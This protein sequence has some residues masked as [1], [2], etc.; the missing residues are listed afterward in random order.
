MRHAGKLEE[1]DGVLQA[2]KEDGLEMSVAL[3]YAFMY[4]ARN[5]LD[6]E[7]AERVLEIY[8]GNGKAME[9]RM[10]NLYLLVYVKS[11]RY[12][13][14]L[15][16]ILNTYA[17]VHDPPDAETFSLVFTAAYRTRQSMAVIDGIVEELLK[18]GLRFSS[19]TGSGALIGYKN[20]SLDPLPDRCLR[21]ERVFNAIQ[22]KT[23]ACYHT[24]ISF[25]IENFD[26]AGALR[27]QR[28]ME[29]AGFSS[30]GT[31]Y[32]MMHLACLYTGMAAYASKYEKLWKEHIEKYPEEKVDR[33]K[34][35]RRY[36]RGR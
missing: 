33:E 19:T 34:R 17:S 29:N 21:A 9:C 22:D 35:R 28:D 12:P 32:K 5:A 7:I 13:Q 2:F 14:D 1:L 16:S 20:C 10:L 31:T 23:Q 3:Y 6:V 30:C 24:M 36:E 25:L 11:G 15:Q 4:S 18:R 8:K 27:L 26:L